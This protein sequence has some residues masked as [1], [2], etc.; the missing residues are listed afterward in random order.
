MNGSGILKKHILK[1]GKRLYK[2]FLIK[3]AKPKKLGFLSPIDFY[4]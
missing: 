3:K 2:V 4:Y 1:A